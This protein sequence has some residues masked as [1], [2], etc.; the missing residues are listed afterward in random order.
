MENIVRAI[1]LTTLASMFLVLGCTSDEPIQERRYRV[2]AT[3]GEDAAFFL[4][5]SSVKVRNGD[6]TG[7]LASE[8][9]ALEGI[10]SIHE[11]L[12]ADCATEEYW[13]LTSI[14]FATHGLS[15]RPLETI[16]REVPERRIAAPGSVGERFV[17]AVCGL[18]A[19]KNPDLLESVYSADI[20][21]S[22]ARSFYDDEEKVS[23]SSIYENIW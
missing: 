14:Y 1:A 5:V 6:L 13:I 11:L 4:D 20:S 21:R 10:R 23:E 17:Q 12:A 3:M 15:G 16:R 18:Q 9:R 7:W 19:N 8:Q 22:V 2:V